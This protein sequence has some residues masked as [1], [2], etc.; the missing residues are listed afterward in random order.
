MRGH[1]KFWGVLAVSLVLIGPVPI[2]A[3]NRSL[4]L[5]GFD[6]GMVVSN[7]T[8]S[9]QL[10]ASNSVM[11]WFK[12]T[13]APP[14]AAGRTL[15]AKYNNAAGQVS[16]ILRYY[17][18]LQT[19]EIDFGDGVRDYTSPRGYAPGQWYHL[20]FTH[21]GS[22][23]RWYVD[24]QLDTAGTNDSVHRFGTNGFYVGRP[25][26]TNST[27]AVWMGYL[28]EISVWKKTLAQA[29]IQLLKNQ[30]LSSEPGLAGYW[31]F[32]AGTGADSSTNGNHGTFLNGT[33]TEVYIVP[34]ND[35]TPV[36]PSP[37][38]MTVIPS[39][40][41]WMGDPF[42]DTAY[43]NETPI[44]SVIVNAFYMDRFEVTKSL[45]DSVASWGASNGYAFS[46]GITG[47]AI[48]H[49]AHNMNW[50]DCVKWCN[51]RS[52]REGL[53]PCYYTSPSMTSVYRFGVL[54][55]QND[56]VRWDASGYRLPNEAEWEWAAR[57]GFIASRFPWGATVGHA[58]A[59]Y[60]GE[61]NILSYDMGP[62]L[63]YHPSY[64][65]GATP[66]TS[67][68]GSFAPNGYGLYDMAGNLEEWCWDQYQER[69]YTN[70]AASVANCP[71]P[72]NGT[73]RVVRG[74]SWAF[75]PFTL[76]C[77]FRTGAAT[78]SSW[79]SFGFRCVR[80]I[81]ASPQ[82]TVPLRVATFNVLDGVGSP[83]SNEYGSVSLI[84]QRINADI[85]AMQE[86]NDSDYP[87]WTNLAAQLSYPYYVRG[88]IGPFSGGLRVGFFSRFPI[89]GV[90]SISS[91]TGAVE[92][93]RSPLR[94]EIEIPGAENPL[95]LWAL[96]HKAFLADDDSFRRAVEAVRV[97]ND[98][99]DYCASYPTRD[100]FV[101]LGDFNDDVARTNQPISFS[102]IPTNMPPGFALGQDIGFPVSYKT[103][104]S[105]RYSDAGIFLQHLSAIQTGTLTN[106]YTS[107][108][109]NDH[110][111]R[112]DYVFVSSGIIRDS[113]GAP[114]SEVYNSV[115]DGAGIGLPK[116][117]V[118]L[119][120]YISSNASDHLAIF[121]DLK[122]RSIPPPVATGLVRNGSFET[123]GS[124]S[125]SAMYWQ[126]NFPDSNGNASGSVERVNWR[127]HFGSWQGTIMGTWRGLGNRGEFWQEANA[128]PGF[129]YRFEG[130]FWADD[131]NP[132]GP[133]AA[134]NQGMRI[135]FRS[136]G[137]VIDSASN[138]FEGVNQIWQKRSVWGM[139][140]PNCDK[141]RIVVY[142]NG[143]G[144]A[145]ALQF[146]D[147]QLAGYPADSD[148]DAL[149]D[150]WE[151][152]NFGTAQATDGSADYDGDGVNNWEEYLADTEP[153]N[154]SSQ[155][156]IIG[157]EVSNGA[158]KVSWQGGRM[159]QQFIQSLAKMGGDSNQWAAV[160]TNSQPPVLITNST[161]LPMSTNQVFFRLRAT[162]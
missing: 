76:R 104:P 109:T 158:A 153:T 60:F 45:W 128:V 51:A 139:A 132:S 129:Q 26:I 85:V 12:L 92:L 82:A 11:L 81:G 136:Q 115:S 78:T 147:L 56:W 134:S 34:T 48:D 122:M 66:Y 43:L 140:P 67:P 29:E 63:G 103:F 13:N 118:P 47:K 107:S 3:D 74:G 97:R 38:L 24:G 64:T 143:A 88:A 17:P 152:L 144:N 131:G 32:D 79:D 137:G 99:S 14:G 116:F 22:V 96:H 86:L 65:N 73:S 93:T 95:V 155:L 156:K 39:G 31:N 54:E 5:D 111:T 101:A 72:A 161:S 69:W 53:K 102:I 151:I 35:V 124:S 4:V 59:N 25:I 37:L 150:Y 80:S 71:G 55:M 142:A 112:S 108:R 154:E 40:A 83:L 7:P 8:A 121:A 160:F 90:H 23:G 130:W 36:E 159:S 146:D 6:D 113:G 145:G 49:P 27:S 50:Y 157:L 148:V 126:T 30:A 42:G 77:S 61:S 138:A 33:Q 114:P 16:Y 120:P 18:Y 123:M 141:I 46:A 119:P 87:Y 28:D 89:I 1:M 57:G 52:E 162:R 68:V 105:E 98:I 110:P 9:L 117:G 94:V 149:P 58:Q 133:W 84:L 2:R 44:H 15:M 127:S 75:S 19:F 20:A 106:L 70:Q 135:E 62:T 91:P 41:V 125:S 10:A 100:E 21:D